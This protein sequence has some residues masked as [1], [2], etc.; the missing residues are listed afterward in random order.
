MAAQGE[1]PMTALV[2]VVAELM[3]GPGRL[4]SASIQA[5]KAI[6]GRRMC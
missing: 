5:T 4:F 1:L 3:E 2:H 6:T